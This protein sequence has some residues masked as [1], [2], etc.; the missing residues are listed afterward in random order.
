[1]ESFLGRSPPS[2]KKKSYESDF[3]VDFADDIL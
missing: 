3:F 2:G 1:M